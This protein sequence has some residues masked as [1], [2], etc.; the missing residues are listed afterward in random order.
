[1][2]QDEI[3]VS[4]WTGGRAV[5]TMRFVAKTRRPKHARLTEPRRFPM[6]KLIYPGDRVRVVRRRS[7]FGPDPLV[8][9]VSVGPEKCNHPY[10]ARML[11][12]RVVPLPTCK[13]SENVGSPLSLTIERS[14][15][16]RSDTRHSA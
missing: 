3:C 7:I 12:L 2:Q 15:V 6:K 8:P 1:M 9:E 10:S 14:F 4:Y 16:F 13:V 11:A 5:S